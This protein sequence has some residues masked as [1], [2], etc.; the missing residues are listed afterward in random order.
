MLD[1]D[2][3]QVRISDSNSKMGAVTSVSLMPFMTCPSCCKDTCAPYCY[4]AKLA[5]LRP[6]VR[7][8][9]AINTAMALYT[10]T[11]Y[12]HGVENAVKRSKYFRFH[13]SGDILHEKYFAEMVRIATDY[14]NRELL[15]FTKRYEII[16]GFLDAGGAIPD[17]LHV[18]FSGWDNLKPH[19]PYRMPETNVIMRGTTP[20]EDWKMCGGNCFNCACRGLGCWQAQPGDIIAFHQH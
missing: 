12:W 17:N 10:P 19:N 9:Y 7:K 2:D 15:C 1:G 8:A 5:N 16:N 11:I 14:P 20:H 13:V 6:A 4:A 18:L 3:L